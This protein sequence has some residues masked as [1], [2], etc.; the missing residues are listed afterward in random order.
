MIVTVLIASALL[1]VIAWRV[2]AAQRKRER[3][4]W[5]YL[6]KCLGCGYDLRGSGE[7]CPECG[8]WI[9]A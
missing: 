5:F 4:S 2:V 8:R 9:W 7:R 3:Q 1:G 6:S